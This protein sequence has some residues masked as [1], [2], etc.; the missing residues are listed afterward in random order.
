M[1]SLQCN[2]EEEWVSIL[3]G[4]FFLLFSYSSKAERKKSSVV[5]SELQSFSIADLEGNQSAISLLSQSL[6]N[7]L[8][9]KK[10]TRRKPP[11]SIKL[12]ETRTLVMNLQNLEEDTGALP[13]GRESKF[14]VRD[15]ILPGKYCGIYR[16]RVKISSPRQSPAEVGHAFLLPTSAV[17]RTQHYQ[18]EF[19]ALA[20]RGISVLK[21]P[22]SMSFFWAVFL[23]IT[24]LCVLYVS[25]S[26]PDTE[27]ERST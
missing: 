15:T 11:R 13:L 26:P 22:W 3:W 5:C 9:P 16:G 19:T 8:T 14:F 7:P 10:S 21:R 27:A 17:T 1:L 6:N 25:L 23:R 18:K 24:K 20:K 2:S 4:E 12:Y